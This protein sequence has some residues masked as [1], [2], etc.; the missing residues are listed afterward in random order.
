MFD[1]SDA[2]K[3][4]LCSTGSAQ[5]EWIEAEPTA[6][7]AACDTVIPR[8]MCKEIPR[9]PSLQPIR[10]LEYEVATGATIPNLGER[11]CL[12]WMEQAA[13]A[14]HIN[15]QVADVHK[16]LLSLS[17]CADMGFE[18]RF[19]RVAGALIDEESGQVILLQQKGN[20]Y[21]LK[22]AGTTRVT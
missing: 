20:L 19:G 11:R 22:C 21:V 2:S 14:R 5:S 1:Y 10:R 7:T 13:E 18:S 6:D 8:T 4:M 16:A 17:R 9:Q 15:M 3:A 12:M